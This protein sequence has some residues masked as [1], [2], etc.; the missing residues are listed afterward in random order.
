MTDAMNIG[1]KLDALYEKFYKDITGAAEH[2]SPNN[3]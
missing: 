1:E 3:F 2:G